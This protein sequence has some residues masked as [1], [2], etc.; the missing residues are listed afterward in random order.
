MK[1]SLQELAAFRS[2]RSKESLDEADILAKSDHWNACINRLYYA[3]FYGVSALLIL[4][5]LS[6]SRH[7]GIRSLFNRNYIK[8]KKIPNQIASI[9]ND[10]FERRQESDYLDFMEFNESQVIPLFPRVEKFLENLDKLIC[11]KTKDKDE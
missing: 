10:L 3:C 6:S 1:G 9:Y 8:T 11:E 7:T 2:K 4:D 5:N